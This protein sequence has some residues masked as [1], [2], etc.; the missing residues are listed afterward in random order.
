MTDGYSLFPNT[1]C[2]IICVDAILLI[3]SPWQDF[4]DLN[5]LRKIFKIWIICGTLFDNKIKQG[6][7]VVMIVA[8]QGAM[9][10]SGY[11]SKP[12]KQ[13]DSRTRRK[14]RSGA[15]KKGR[16]PGYTTRLKSSKES[17]PEAFAEQASS[18]D[19]IHSLSNVLE[20]EVPTSSASWSGTLTSLLNTPLRSR[21]RLP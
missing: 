18:L 14:G 11:S 12:T 19:R 20:E 1:N 17:R 10:G 4:Q 5:N 3:G 9:R 6:A 15:G 13:G 7:M 16:W 8:G 21:L 2:K